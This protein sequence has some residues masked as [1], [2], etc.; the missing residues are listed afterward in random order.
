MN[1]FIMLGGCIAVWLLAISAVVMWWKRRPKERLGAPVVPPEPR[2]R[3]AVL[4]I[5]LPL[6]IL[7]PLT[8]VNLLAALMI[9]LCLWRLGLW[10]GAQGA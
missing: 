10:R 4:A 7:Y 2:L 1:Q 8:G 6:L 5:V 3:A 9:D